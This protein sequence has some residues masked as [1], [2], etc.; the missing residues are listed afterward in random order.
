ID[1]AFTPA[2]A[3]KL[4]AEELVAVAGVLG[5]APRA[6]ALAERYRLDWVA[7]THG[8]GGT[9]VYRGGEEATAAVPRFDSDPSADSVG[10]G[11][12]CGAGLLFGMLQGW[13]L[14]RTVALAN[15]LGAY[16]ASQ[17]GATPAL[18]ESLVRA[19]R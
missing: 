17:P 9:K 14:E 15:T 8:A 2:T 5:I 11:D 6:A 1:R 12:A 4:N 19:C 18:P 13:P 16:V 7:V 10:A 3:A